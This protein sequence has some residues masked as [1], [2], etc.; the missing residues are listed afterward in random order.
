[1]E[2]LHIS[3]EID[4]LSQ[5]HKRY[6]IGKKCKRKQLPREVVDAIKQRKQAKKRYAE[7]VKSN[8]NPKLVEETWNEYVDCKR[9]AGTKK[10]WFI[11]FR[12]RN[13]NI[14]STHHTGCSYF[15]SITPFSEVDYKIPYL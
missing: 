13:I 1:M 12:Q 3:L 15:A 10:S 5:I 2:L 11:L 9:M 8:Q 6:I 7:A 14:K 4:S